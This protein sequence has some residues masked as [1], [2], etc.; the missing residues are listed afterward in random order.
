MTTSA[1]GAPKSCDSNQQGPPTTQPL[2]IK[3]LSAS[4]TST[5][6]MKIPPPHP[7]PVPIQ[8]FLN[9]TPLTNDTPQ[10]M[11]PNSDTPFFDCEPDVP[12][13]TECFDLD[14]FPRDYPSF[15]YPPGPSFAE[16]VNAVNE[17]ISLGTLP[18]PTIRTQMLNSHFD[19]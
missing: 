14:Y 9:D 19:T 12:L 7:E 10:L 18:K 2:R 5:A 3:K 17:L 16:E 6:M 1:N 13:I 11:P 15:E 8:L 4:A